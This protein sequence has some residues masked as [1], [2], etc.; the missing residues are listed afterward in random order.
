MENEVTID[1]AEFRS[2]L[3]RA[4]AETGIVPNDEFVAAFLAEVDG[5]V[6]LEPWMLPGLVSAYVEGVVIAMMAG[7]VTDRVAQLVAERLKNQFR[8]I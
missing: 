6:D 7:P 1:L 8:I 4:F 5:L 3:D 2:A